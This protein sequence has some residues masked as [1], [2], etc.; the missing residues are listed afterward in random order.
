MLCPLTLVE[1]E[2]LGSMGRSLVEKSERAVAGYNPTCLDDIAEWVA[3]HYHIIVLARLFP[4]NSMSRRDLGKLFHKVRRNT[5]KTGEAR[6]ATKDHR[7]AGSIVFR[8]A[9]KTT[10]ATT[11]IP[12]YGVGL[13]VFSAWTGE[14][15]VIVHPHP[16]H[17]SIL[18]KELLYV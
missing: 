13:N 18:I 15:A 17:T 5:K 9:C 4:Y 6:F 16:K 2:V 14:V 8:F 1:G 11:P 7:N 3:H 12:L 10:G